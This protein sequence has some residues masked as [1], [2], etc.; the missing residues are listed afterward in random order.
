MRSGLRRARFLPRC[1]APYA[2]FA[3]GAIIVVFPTVMN[4]QLTAF[5]SMTISPDTEKKPV[6]AVR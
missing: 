6:G 2:F 4:H 5:E 1:C 3:F